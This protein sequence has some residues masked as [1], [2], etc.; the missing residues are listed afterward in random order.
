MTPVMVDDSYDVAV[1]GAGPAGLTAASIK[2]RA[3]LSTVLFDEQA[4]AGG[5]IYRSI[6][7]TPVTQRTVLG[8]SY[9][10][11]EKLV[12]EFRS[13][14]AQYVPGATVWSVSREREIGVS[15]SGGSHLTNA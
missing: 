5:Q 12:E 9:W 3:G 14:G 7:E 1:I 11:G 13:S 8:A 4:S 15:L 6:T 10:E 2:A